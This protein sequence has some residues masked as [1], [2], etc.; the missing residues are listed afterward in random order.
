M[1]PGITLKLFAAILAASVV[2]ATA[3]ALATRYSFHSG[4]LGYLAQVDAQRLDALSHALGE[5]YRRSGSWDFV[6]GDYAR[7]RDIAAAAS[8]PQAT[9]R[10]TVLD[11]AQ[12]LVVGNPELA[13]DE[14]VRP[15]KVGGEVVGWVGRAPLRRL[16]SAAEESF[17]AQQQRAAWAIAGLALALA[18]A[19]AV[20]LARTFLLPIKRVAAAT[21]RLA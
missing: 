2:A 10:L 4:F 20:V 16:S 15:V 3:M 17:E 13:R 18:A 7:L 6:R 19:L 8:F 11:G 9:Q 1:Q 5:E 14:T 12:R 21:H